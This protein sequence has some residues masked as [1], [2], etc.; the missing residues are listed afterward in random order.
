M[1]QLTLTGRGRRRLLG[2]HP[3]IYADDVAEGE[4]SPGELLPLTGPNA[5]ALGWGLFSSHSKIAVRVVTRDPQQPNREFWLARVRDAVERRA[6]DGMLAPDGAC[7]LLAGDADR[8]PGLVVD[9]YAGVLVLQSGG[10]AG[11]RMRD[12]LLELVRECLPFEPT[13]VL[14]RSDTSVR[15]LEGLESRVEWLQGEATEPVEVVEAPADGPRLVYEVDVVGGHKTGAYLD[16]SRNRQHAAR[17]ADGGDVLDAFSYDGL[18]GIRAALAG[19]RSVLCVDQSDACGERVLRNAER[20]GVSD[21]VRFERTNAMKDLR[22]LEEAGERYSLVVVDPPAFARNKREAAGAARGYREVNR[23]AA[24]M[25][26]PGGALVASSCSYAV[27]A[28]EF[29]E[30][31]AAGVR[32]AGR[33]GWLLEL[34]GAAPDHPLRLAVPETGYL[35]CATVRIAP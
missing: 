23:R 29:V 28:P 19:A 4:G 8:L 25:V 13:A 11:D 24:A 31:V 26:L 16:Q 2:G 35:K 7:R 30:H 20:N 5:D 12:F 1:G 6:R 14:D 10:Q 22:R 21:R 32:D 27:R 33:E 18:F 15:R 9:Q 34:A 17:F 3:W